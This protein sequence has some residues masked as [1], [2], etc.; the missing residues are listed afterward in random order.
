MKRNSNWFFLVNIAQFLRTTFLQ[1]ISCGC[2]WIHFLHAKAVIWQCSGKKVFL[3]IL[4]NSQ[5]NT[6]KRKKRLSHKCFPVNFTKLIR[7]PFLTE[8]LY[9]LHHFVIENIENE[10]SKLTSTWYIHCFKSCF[11]LSLFPFNLKTKFFARIFHVHL[12]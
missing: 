6:Q 2:F 11:N 10:Y 12:A 8:Y 7:A 5:E 4:Q 9:L 3:E 1:K